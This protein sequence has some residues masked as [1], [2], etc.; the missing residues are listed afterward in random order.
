MKDGCRHETLTQAI[1]LKKE[2]VSVIIGGMNED[3][4]VSEERKNFSQG[5]KEDLLEEE[6]ELSLER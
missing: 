4:R 1:Y 2:H 3:S 5:T 6:F